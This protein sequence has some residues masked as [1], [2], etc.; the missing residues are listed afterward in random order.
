MKFRKIQAY[1]SI[2]ALT[3]FSGIHAQSE[4]AAIVVNIDD[5]ICGWATPT[6]FSLGRIE[7]VLN[8]SGTWLLSCHG[9]V[10]EGELP[11]RAVVG[12]STE[13]NPLGLC[14]IGGLSTLTWQITV[15][16]SG[17]SKFTCH[18]VIE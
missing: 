2:I 9:E 6:T 17:K 7:A 13:D 18:G 15:A 3:M 14:S 16:P 5:D 4:N 11:D 8:S 1:V 10:V 12:R